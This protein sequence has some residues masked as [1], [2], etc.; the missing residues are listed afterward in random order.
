M[1]FLVEM[2]TPQDSGAG[3]SWIILDTWIVLT[4][5]ITAMA[6]ALPGTFLVLRRQS[7]MGDALTH[8]VLPGIVGAFLFSHFLKASG[9]IASDTS[10]HTQAFDPTSYA[11]M[12]GGAILIGVLTAVLTEWVQ[13]H[14]RVENSAA[15]GVIYTT[16][17]AAGLLLIRIAAD[18]VHI[19]P[20]CVL[21]GNI[22]GV[23]DGG[24]ETPRATQIG[25]GMLVINGLLT[26]VFFK[27]LRISTFD[28]ALATTLG[29]SATAINYGLMAITAA[30]AVAA[31]ESVGN[32]LVISM[33]IVP[34]ATAHLLTDRLWL[35]I[36]LSLAIAAASAFL[37]HLLA[38]TLPPVLLAPFADL[39]LLG[40]VDVTS[41]DVSTSGMMAAS[42]G[43]F[44]F[45]AMLLGPRHGL[46]IRA[47]QRGLLALRIAGEDLLGVLYRQLENDADDSPRPVAMPTTLTFISRI[48]LWRLRQQGLVQGQANAARLTASGRSTAQ[49][50]I[51]S[52]RLWETYMS[53]HFDVPGDHLHEAAHRAEHFIDED[54]REELARELEAPKTDPHGRD[55]PTEE[56]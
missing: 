7:M 48:A 49:Q 54:I 27:E 45:A 40:G 37:G 11:L 28:P 29:I 2:L 8:T 52:H 30:T 26:T 6:C 32:I 31:F 18:S 5:A 23:W 51:R 10:Q 41:I 53:R 20:D 36:L 44:F 50:L 46:L 17:F 13:K 25:F 19:D 22:E 1:H 35:T 15:L 9:I 16:M 34:A 42:S 39:K 33:L 4:A 38:I 43:L 12:F 14:G 24:Q 3:S 21:Y 56:T 47:L 55:I